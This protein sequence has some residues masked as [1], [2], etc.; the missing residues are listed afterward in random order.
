MAFNVSAWAIRNP[1]PPFVM[2]C[3]AVAVGAVSFFFLP[4]TRMPS[5][6]VPVVAVMVE[7]AGAAPS[8]LET[9]VARRIEDAVAGLPGLRRVSSC[10]GEGTSLTIAEFRLDTPIDRAVVDVRDAVA[11]VRSALPPSVQEPLI[12]RVEA[13]GGAIVT[14][15]VASPSMSLEDLSWFVDDTVARALQGVSGVAQVTREGG[16]RREIGIALDPA[17]LQALGVTAADVNA[18]LGMSSLDRAGGRAEGGGEERSIR[19]LSGAADLDDLRRTVIAL[20]GGRD[21][22]LGDLGTVTDGPAE[23]R[24][25]AALDGEP[26]VAFG[27]R[28]AA[29]HSDVSVAAAVA[30]RLETLAKAHPGVT[31]RLIDTTV[32]ETMVSYRNAIATLIEGAALA[33]VVVLVFLRD[34]RATAITSLAIPLSILPT[35]FVMHML[36]FSLNVVSLLAIVLVTGIL[37]DD[38]IVEIENIDR[39]MRMGASPYR[40]AIAGSEEIG[41]AVMATTLTIV[42]V[43]LPVSFMGGII[44]QYFRQFGVTVAVAVSFSLLVARFVT[45]LLAAYGLK[46]HKQP[47]RAEGPVM[48]LYLDA[49]RW[50]LRRRGVTLGA[51]AAILAG[52]AMLASLLPSEF[53]P[54]EDMSRS[55]LEVE[56]P[57]GST[58]D[59]TLAVARNLSRLLKTRPEVVSVYAKAGGRDDPQ[60]SSAADIRKAELVITLTPPSERRLSQQAFERLVQ[61]AIAEEPDIR[62]NFAKDG[63][64]PFSLTVSGGDGAAVMQAAAKLET[65]IR[66]LPQLANVVTTAALDRPEIRITP[67]LADAARHGVSAAQIAD[68]TRVALIGDIAQNLAKLSTG[69]RQI[70]I[71]VQLD[72]KARTD[73]ATLQTLRVRSSRGGSVPLAAVA[74]VSFGAGPASVERRDRERQITI[75]ADLA[76]GVA[77]GQA[78][79][80]V[81]ALPE[82]KTLPEG[83]S[84]KESG[85]AEML[86][87]VFSSFALAMASGVLLVFAVLALLFRDLLQP[88]TILLSLPLSMG[89]A[90]LALLLTGQAIGLPAAIGFLMLMGIVTK[91][92]ILL[93]DFAVD[94]MA[95]GTGRVEALVGA[96]RKRAMPI[97]MTTIAMSAGMLPAAL[98]AGGPS[99]FQ[100]PIAIAVIGGLVA[101]TALSLIFVPAAFTVM[102]DVRLFAGR[103][104]GP[105]VGPSEDFP[106]GPALQNK[107]S[108]AVSRRSPS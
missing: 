62:A 18:E 31:I 99:A 59:Q 57:A 3:V 29:G 10:L 51:G 14:Y 96:G 43:F 60:S 89:G 95:R 54:V 80:A 55:V 38:A 67:R 76:P 8:E 26:I 74:D 7:Q 9:Q 73:I 102:D 45:P 68:T 25:A 106:D 53:M 21:A 12:R 56:L 69:E 100:A 40:A 23:R 88:L 27:V 41:L 13:E 1:I 97:L 78:L 101:S 103:A 20:P 34:A 90:F 84:L 33:V 70:D 79:A 66:G 30:A 24:S 39:H 28:R 63:E 64:R 93:V 108:P 107:T 72:G 87:E 50:T 49:L 32:T 44:G 48:R 35:F 16:A 86:A 75:N 37:V 91:N 19:V 52:S 83:V 36:G 92:A 15:G 5:V 82:A 22:R 11:S 105:L 77:L 42:A 94:A 47:E 17:R 2:F 104:F 4:V 6:D 81:A 85:D 65:A 71:R 98:S 46:D 58:L 61:S